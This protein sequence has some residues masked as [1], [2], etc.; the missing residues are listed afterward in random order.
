LYR[1][2]ERVQLIRAVRQSLAARLL[3]LFQASE[4]DV[5]IEVGEAAVDAHILIFG[6]AEFDR[7]DGGEI[8][9]V[10]RDFDQVF[11]IDPLRQLCVALLPD[12]RD[13]VFPCLDHPA[14]V[15]VG[16]AEQ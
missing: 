8:L 16:A 15:G 2:F 3:L 4:V 6:F 14:N 11:G 9:R 10:L 7:A 12:L 13:V 1:F 5:V